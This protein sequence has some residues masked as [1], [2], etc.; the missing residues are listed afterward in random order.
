MQRKNETYRF[1]DRIDNEAIFCTDSYK[2]YIQFAQNLDI[3]LQQINR[4]RH[5][6]GIYHIQHINAIIKLLSLTKIYEERLIY[7]KAS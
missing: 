2:S 4:G 7:G 3:E 6:E 5:K 1:R